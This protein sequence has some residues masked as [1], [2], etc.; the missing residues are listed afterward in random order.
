L[1][2]TLDEFA[3]E[4]KGGCF[5]LF[6]T[7]CAAGDTGTLLSWSVYQKNS[8]DPTP[9]QDASWTELKDVYAD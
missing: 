3:G 1:K 7:D 6:I 4:A 5:N 9:T 2:T 8:D